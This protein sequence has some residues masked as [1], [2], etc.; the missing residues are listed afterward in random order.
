MIECVLNYTSIYVRKRVKLDSELW[1]EHVPKSVKTSEE[2]SFTILWNQ[3]VQTDR[4]IPNNKPDII[5]RDNEE[6][7]CMLVD[8]TIPGDRNVIKKGA[9]KI[10]KYKD[11]IIEIQRMWNVKTK[12][13]PVI[14]G[15][16]ETISKSF[17]KYLSSIQGKHAVKELQ[18][19][20]I[21]GTAHI[22]RKVLM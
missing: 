18:K 13:T 6:R 15:A 11:L 19:T 3:R 20:A 5:I 10:V 2:G 22:L 12:V 21:L 4:N 8:V 7:T 14:I 16:T 1:Y 9:E 17:R